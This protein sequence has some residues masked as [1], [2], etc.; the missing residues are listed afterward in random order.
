[1]PTRTLAPVAATR[2]AGATVPGDRSSVRNAH[3]TAAGIIRGDRAQRPRPGCLR[4][5]DRTAIPRQG[6]SGHARH[7]GTRGQ[8]P[9]KYAIRASDSVR[10]ER[11]G[12]ACTISPSALGLMMQ[13]R[14]GSSKARRSESIGID[15]DLPF[16]NSAYWHNSKEGDGPVQRFGFQPRFSFECRFSF[17]FPV[18]FRIWDLRPDF[19]FEI[20]DLGIPTRGFSAQS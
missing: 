18:L 6:H 20:S 2:S 9:T 1:M 17:E 5:V 14:C 7:P 4:T 15:R 11:I 13:I 8:P 19:G 10:A 12:K 16:P 3:S